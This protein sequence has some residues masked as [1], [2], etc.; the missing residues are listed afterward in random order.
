MAY[1]EYKIVC[2]VRVSCNKNDL[3]CLV[4]T[5]KISGGTACV[6]GRKAYIKMGC[7]GLVTNGKKHISGS[8]SPREAACITEHKAEANARQVGVNSC[9]ERAAQLTCNCADGEC[10]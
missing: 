1:A 8:R 2:G 3:D 9:W 5:A 10:G 7:C 4:V 6:L